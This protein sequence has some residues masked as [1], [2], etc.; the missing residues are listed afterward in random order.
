MA[1]L[2]LKSAICHFQDAVLHFLSKVAQSFGPV[3]GL[4]KDQ[5]PLMLLK[6]CSTMLKDVLSLNMRDLRM[7]QNRPEM[8]LRD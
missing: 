2:E 6:N 7:Q 8:E 3:F 4:L 5:M 1:A